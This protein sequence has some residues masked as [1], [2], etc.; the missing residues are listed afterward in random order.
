M[1][2]ERREGTRGK[3]KEGR[4]RERRITGVFVSAHNPDWVQHILQALNKCYG[5]KTEG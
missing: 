4:E 2:K 1:K 5:M 3:G